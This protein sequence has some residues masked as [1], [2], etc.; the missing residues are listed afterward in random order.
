MSSGNTESRLRR[1][2][3]HQVTRST[4]ALLVLQL[5]NYVV[6]LVVLPYL[7][8]R[9]TPELLGVV[10]MAM[11]IAYI[12]FVLCDYG[13]A[14]SGTYRVAKSS[15]DRETIGRIVGVA[16]ALKFALWGVAVVATQAFFVMNP[17][18]AE[19]HAVMSLT[20]LT[21]LAHAIQLP[22]VFQGMQRMHHVARIGATTG[23][24]YMALVLL[25][26]QGSADYGKAVLAHALAHVFGAAVAFQALRSE[27]VS[28]R[29]PSRI[30]ITAELRESASYFLSRLAVTTW[31]NGSTVALGVL[32]SPTYAAVFYVA[33]RIYVAITAMTR[34]LIQ[35]M[36]PH[37]VA[38]R[39]V[40]LLRQVLVVG[41]LVVGL[42]ALAIG[43][44]ADRLVPFVFGA[45]YIASIPVLYVLLVNSVVNYFGVMIGYPLFGSYGRPDIANTTVFMG[46][47]AFV[48][49]VCWLVYM[50]SL[51]ALSI[52]IVFLAAETVITLARVVFAFRIARGTAG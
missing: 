35:A 17:A 23:V 34:P 3:Q 5:A 10:A 41:C 14:V 1:I 52:A 22:W 50:N 7:A 46:W 4:L 15:G 42:V 9:L 2:R 43:L 37:M 39:N 13:F 20:G 33:Q 36:Y 38:E 48:L 31:T 19:H 32:A 24:V 51:T 11:S 21:I 16:L 27:G 12:G 49:G 8:W 26:V 6:P 18:T 30:E 44:A 28:V 29:W 40:R 25:L 45:A 47:I